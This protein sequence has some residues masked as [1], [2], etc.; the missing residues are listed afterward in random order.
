MLLELSMAKTLERYHKSSYGLIESQQ[1]PDDE[2]VTNQLFLLYINYLSCI[3]TLEYKHFQLNK[4]VLFYK[5]SSYLECL[6][7]K[8][9]VEVLQQSQRYFIME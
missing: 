4:Y 6:K 2:R 1:S 3:L 8:S 9:R 5:Q 7:L